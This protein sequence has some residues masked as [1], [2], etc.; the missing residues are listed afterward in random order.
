MTLYL[1]D[2]QYHYAL[3][4]ADSA[5]E[6]VGCNRALENEIFFLFVF[7]I[8]RNWLQAE[9]TFPQKAVADPAYMYPNFMPQLSSDF[10]WTSLLLEGLATRKEATF[11]GDSM[12]KY[13]FIIKYITGISSIA[14]N[15]KKERK[16]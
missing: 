12:R 7:S 2:H 5:A 11:R 1:C 6:E 16:R 15:C 8:K 14:I 9:D 13:S 10:W 4:I 3:A